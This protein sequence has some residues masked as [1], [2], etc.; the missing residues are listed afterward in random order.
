VFKKYKAIVQSQTIFDKCQKQN[1]NYKL[2]W[3]LLNVT[4]LSAQQLSKGQAHKAFYSGNFAVDLS[5]SGA[6]L[7]WTPGIKH[8]GS[9]LGGA[10][11]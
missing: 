9:L 7:S 8:L 11:G 1:A 4:P 6:F 10:L 5:N 2:W 3:F